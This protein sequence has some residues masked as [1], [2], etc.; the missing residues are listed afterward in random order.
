M[1]G[2]T[3]GQPQ[4][5]SLID[6]GY[7]IAAGILGANYV[8]Y[9]PQSTGPV[10]ANVNMVQEIFLAFDRDNNFSFIKPAEYNKSLYYGLVDLTYVRIGDFFYNFGKH[11]FFVA[12][13]EPLRPVELVLCNHTISLYR[14]AGSTSNGYGGD[15]DP[16]LQFSEW[17]CS[18]LP[19]TKGESNEARTPGSIRAPWEIL[20]IPAIPGGILIDEYDLLIDELGR[21]FIISQCSLAKEGW[22]A[23]VSEELS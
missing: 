8:Q 16:I 7:G 19:G 11:T 3:F 10:L 15:T 4:I 20:Q 14:P 2:A 5:Q 21:R 22:Y 13:I 17:P 23:T 18:L 1:S 9:R 6:L 12:N